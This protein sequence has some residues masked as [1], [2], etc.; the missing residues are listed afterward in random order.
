MTREV[1]TFDV[2]LEE[3]ALF[4]R[5]E[6]EPN[7][8]VSHSYVPGSA[9]RGAMLHAPRDPQ[10][11][12]AE[13]TELLFLSGAVRFLNAYPLA[14]H[15]DKVERALPTPGTWQADK[16]DRRKYDGARQNPGKQEEWFVYDVAAADAPPH[17]R[18]ARVN[19]PFCAEFQT[20]PTAAFVSISRQLAIH[21]QRDRDAGRAKRDSGAVYRYESLRLGQT[22]RAHLLCDWPEHDANADAVTAARA[23]LRALPQ[24]HVKLGGARNAGY[25]SAVI[26]REAVVSDRAGRWRELI[27]PPNKEPKDQTLVTLLSDALVQDAFGNFSAEADA[28]ALGISEALGLPAG[29]LRAEALGAAQTPTGGFNRTWGLP[30]PQ[31]IGVTMGSVYRLTGVNL[32][33]EQRAQLEWRGIGKRL[34]DGFGRL[35]V[36]WHGGAP[37]FKPSR[38]VQASPSGV[39]LAKDTSAGKLAL[40]TLDHL[41]RDK[42]EA[43]MLSMSLEASKRITRPSAS[44]L[45]RLQTTLRDEINTVLQCRASG[46]P[47]TDASNA[48]AFAA[49]QKRLEKQLSDIEARRR[50]APR[51]TRDRM[52]G[53]HGLLSWLRS[54]ILWN[55]ET[56]QPGVWAVELDALP[57]LGGL[58]AEYTPELR[59][60]FALRFV[61]DTLAMS[62]ARKKITTQE[63]HA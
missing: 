30:L 43:Q 18:P 29:V 56:N 62:A 59:Y 35:I 9:L 10:G 11:L 22:F 53:A 31:Y 41:L 39:I 13:A 24:L 25:G 47:I 4:A 28:V 33:A 60:E 20:L 21:T 32:T 34:I 49:S 46:A 1:F 57:R 52:E 12:G 40:R 6:G 55:P 2:T 23:W 16:S 51:F 19:A 37:S 3:P 17:V 44:Q 61:H 45:R 48:Q 27:P 42:L 26:R 8:A 63:T 50:M 36:N 58:T 54:R 14:T 5:I 15:I 38:T 7:S